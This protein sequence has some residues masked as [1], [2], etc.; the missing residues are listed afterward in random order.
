MEGPDGQLHMAAGAHL[1]AN[2]RHTFFAPDG[3][4]IIMGE[5]LDRDYAPQFSHRRLNILFRGFAEFEGLKF[6][7]VGEQL[8]HNRS[9]ANCVPIPRHMTLSTLHPTRKKYNC[10]PNRSLRLKPN[11]EESANFALSRRRTCK[12]GKRRRDP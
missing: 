9:R 11:A 8:V 3:E 6:E 12:V 4:P 7:K 5:D 1:I 10:P 2:H